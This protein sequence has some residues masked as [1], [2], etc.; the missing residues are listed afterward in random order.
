ME[1]IKEIE[2]ELQN[3]LKSTSDLDAVHNQELTQIIHNYQEYR[4]N[5]EI[6]L[7]KLDVMETE[8]QRKLISWRKTQIATALLG[9]T[10]LSKDHD[11]MLLEKKTWIKL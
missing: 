8:L 6:A 5:T 10:K 2:F 4:R 9:A 11:Q 1:T 7:Q 3:C